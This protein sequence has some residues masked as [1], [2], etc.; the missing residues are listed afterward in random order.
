[1]GLIDLMACSNKHKAT[2]EGEKEQMSRVGD[3]MVEVWRMGSPTP[4]ECQEDMSVPSL[5]APGDVHEKALKGSRSLTASRKSTRHSV[6]QI[7]D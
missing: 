4:I 6:F 2:I 5:Q 7:I 3:I 1:M